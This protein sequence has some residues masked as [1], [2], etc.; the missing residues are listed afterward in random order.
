MPDDLFTTDADA[1][2]PEPAPTDRA[3]TADLMARLQRHYIKPGQPLPGGVFLPEVGWNGTANASRVDALYVGFTGT[4]GRILIGHEV[5][6]SRSDWLTELSKP[7]KAD[8]W[9]DQCHEWWLVTVPGVVKDGE[10]PDGW[11]L[12]HPGTGKTRMRVVCPARRHHGRT[13]S[14]DATRSIIARQDTLRAQAILDGAT[15]A[16]KEA[17]ADVDERV[18]RQIEQR[19][20]AQPDA[21]EVT[22]RLAHIEAALGGRLADDDQRYLFG[23]Q[24]RAVELSDVAALLRTH[25]TLEDAT[26]TL[27]GRYATRELRR[28]ADVLADLQRAYD[29]A[30]GSLPARPAE[31]GA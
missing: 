2:K 15:K 14:W 6:A 18:T 5:K 25:R 21:T 4:S 27:A 24:F 29:D 30:V 13:P 16:R 22:A 26:R 28:L 3:V 10:L 8:A 9:A 12:M 23:D 17:Q 11:G 7:G 1:P 19:L 31:V 20:H